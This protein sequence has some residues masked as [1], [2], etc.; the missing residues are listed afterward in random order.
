MDALSLGY[1]DFV[2]LFID[3]GIS[4]DKLTLADIEQLYAAA[5]VGFIHQ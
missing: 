2:E 1:A 5:D 3:Y 4:L